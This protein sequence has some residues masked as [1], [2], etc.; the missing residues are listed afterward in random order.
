MILEHLEYKIEFKC[1]KSWM[2]DIDW[3]NPY[4]DQTTH[5]VGYIESLNALMSQP[6]FWKN[7]RMTFIFSKWGLGSLLGL[8]KL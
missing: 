2:N 5:F 8:S 1:K 4:G 6:H 3:S 7:V